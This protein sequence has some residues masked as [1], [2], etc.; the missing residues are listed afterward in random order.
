MTSALFLVNGANVCSK[1]KFN[2]KYFCGFSLAL[3]VNPLNTVVS[4]K[5]TDFAAEFHILNAD[6]TWPL[7]FPIG[8]QKVMYLLYFL[9][10]SFI[11]FSSK[12]VF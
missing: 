4:L 7:L 12:G 9:G 6:E 8:A 11:F 2:V 3:Q 10:G 1:V 5:R